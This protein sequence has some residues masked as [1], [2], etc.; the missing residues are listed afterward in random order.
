MELPR[1]QLG[2]RRDVLTVSPQ[3][4]PA[5]VARSKAMAASNEAEFK[6][7]VLR[8]REK[9]EGE[10]KDDTLYKCAL[11]SEEDTGGNWKEKLR[12]PG[13]YDTMINCNFSS[14]DFARAEI[15][16]QTS[17]NMGNNLYS[18]DALFVRFV[19]PEK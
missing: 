14:H 7:L 15:D 4:P 12:Q 8:F 5:L 17:I 18:R 6:A 13:A 16:E 9:E 1:G 3:A 2:V 10:F 19:P 11:G